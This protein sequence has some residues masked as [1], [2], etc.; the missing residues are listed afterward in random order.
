[1]ALVGFC[2]VK[3][4]GTN[5]LEGTGVDNSVVVSLGNSSFRFTIVLLAAVGRSIMVYGCQ[6]S[7][8]P[9]AFFIGRC[10]GGVTT[11]REGCESDRLAW[12]GRHPMLQ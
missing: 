11:S 4:G 12:H 5:A 8:V 6:C 1:M 3:A 10:R 9:H 2:G 7:G